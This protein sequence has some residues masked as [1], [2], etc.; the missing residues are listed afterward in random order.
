MNFLARS[1]EG[2]EYFS[3][4]RQDCKLTSV[5]KYKKLENTIKLDIL[6]LLFLACFRIDDCQSKPIRSTDNGKIIVTSSN[7]R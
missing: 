4:N 3:F 2:I 6:L 5:L 1:K 7:E